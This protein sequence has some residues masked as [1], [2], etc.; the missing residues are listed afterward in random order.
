MEFSKIFSALS[1]KD[2]KFFPLFNQAAQNLVDISVLL[3]KLILNNEEKDVNTLCTNI[4]EMEKKG[5]ELAVAVYKELN[6]TFITPFDREDIQ[7]LASSIDDVVDAIYGVSIKIKLFSPKSHSDKLVKM[8]EILQHSCLMIKD[9]VNGLNKLKNPKAIEEACNSINLDESAADELYHQ[10]IYDLFH[11]ET[12]AIELIKKKE[13]LQTLEK[14][15]DQAEDVSD[16][17]K[18][19][20]VKSS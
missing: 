5:D 11:S 1:P 13:I 10:G 6:G 7:E 16:V 4:K 12:D 17:L 3:H 9:A 2:R 19:I 20:L 15:T 14:A 8:S 18:T